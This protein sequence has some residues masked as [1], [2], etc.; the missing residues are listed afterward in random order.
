MKARRSRGADLLCDLDN[1]DYLLGN[2]SWNEN[3]GD[4]D[5]FSEKSLRQSEC[6]SRDSNSQ[7]NEVMNYAGSSVSNQPF[8]DNRV[9]LENTIFLR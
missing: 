1:I 3:E 2:L 5:S 6:Q 4:P 7:D 9:L 8:D